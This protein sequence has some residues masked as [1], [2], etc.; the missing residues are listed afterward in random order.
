[1]RNYVAIVRKEL[2][3]LFVSPIAYVVLAVFLGVTGLYFYS[4]LNFYVS[5]TLE[6]ML[7]AQQ[8]GSGPPPID[9]PFEIM[10]T[11]FGILSTF[12]LLSVPAVT[13]GIFSE[14]KRRGTMELL[15]TSPLS[16][17]Q[18]VLGKFTAAALFL[19]I[20]LVPTMLNTLVLYFYS[21]P[22]LAWTPVLAGYL[23]AFLLGGALLSIGVFL[24]SVTENQIV[25]F[26][27]TLGVFLV[28]WALDWTAE[29]GASF[30]S[31]VLK[32]LSVLNHY[33]DFTKGTLDT[34]HVVFYLSFIFL[35]M[36]LTSISLDT[37]KWRQ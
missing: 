35:G 15:A 32:Y 36:F 10:R 18:L 9:V 12:L 27:T 29:S 24:S 13:M 33:D 31:E 34:Q 22:R 19:S 2:H 16:S 25:A 1:M 21:E 14:E 5:R 11:F 3:T 23:G 30:W 26:F 17:L 8:F 4:I 7:R 28:L 20:M 37:A 6:M